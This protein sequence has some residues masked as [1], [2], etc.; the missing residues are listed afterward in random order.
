MRISLLAG[1]LAL[2][3]CAIGGS[4]VFTLFEFNHF[5]AI[6][7]RFDGACSPVSG[8]AGPEDIEIA[9]SLGRAFI[10]SLDRRAAS[11]TR[12]AVFSVLVSDPLDSD[13][14]R[15]RTGGEPADFRPLGLSY[16]EEGDTRRLFAVNEASNSVEIFDVRP[17][18]DLVH[19]ETVRERRFTSPNDIAAIGPRSFYLTNDVNAGRR[20]LLGKFQFLAR[21][22]TGAIFHFD[23]VTTRVAADGLRFA[24]GVTLNASG[25]RLYAAETSGRALRIYDRDPASG[26]LTLAAIEPLPAAPDN[27]T[28]AADGSVWIGAQPK[29]LAIPV[30]ERNENILAPSL[31]IRYADAMGGESSISEVYSNSGSGISTSTVAAVSGGKLLIGALYDDKYLI[32]D[33][34]NR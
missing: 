21:S 12:G 5:A 18:G 13:N 24:N 6:E 19:L 2:L 9:P 26:F 14:W 33:L 31:V 29:P 15:D 23:G 30:A 28:I 27:L 8:V 3:I 10:S 22:P 4:V 7:D 1:G 34:P 20:S 25:A 16:F 11:D 32:C 17:D